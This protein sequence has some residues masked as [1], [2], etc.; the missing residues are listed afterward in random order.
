MASPAAGDG[1]AM[2]WRG[3]GVLALCVGLAGVLLWFEGP[4]RQETASRALTFAAG[5][6]PEPTAPTPRL[7]DFLPSEVVAVELEHGG[8][9]RTAHRDGDTWEG[10][11]ASSVVND[12]LHNISGL[13]VLAEI[14]A[15]PAD[16][17]DYGLEPPQSVLVL[18]LRDRAQ[19]LVLQ[20]GDRNPATTGVYVRI[21][22]NGPVVL[23]GALVTWEFDKAFNGLAPRSADR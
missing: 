23:A 10:T 21:G 5:V 3:T 14:P 17:K 19:P 1:V 20:I 18:Q 12:F 13:G 6:A 15:A 22:D 11:N 8:L 7:L 2:G 4:A 16:L 9:T